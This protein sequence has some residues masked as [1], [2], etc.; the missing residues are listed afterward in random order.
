MLCCLASF[1][2]VTSFFYKLI[3]IHFVK[4]FP[5]VMEL[6]YQRILS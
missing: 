4:K 5:S 6:T 1:L 2:N 3:C